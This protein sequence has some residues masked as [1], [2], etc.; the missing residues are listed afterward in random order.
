MHLTRT[1]EKPYWE[2]ADNQRTLHG[3]PA[4]ALLAQHAHRASLHLSGS[5]LCRQLISEGFPIQ[6]AKRFG[7][8]F[9][10]YRDLLAG[11]GH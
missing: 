11:R 8:A 4:L 5:T 1:R 3:W 10:Y 6:Q 9:D 2:L 7:A